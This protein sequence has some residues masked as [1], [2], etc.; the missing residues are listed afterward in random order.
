MSN[1]FNNFKLDKWWRI[2]LWLGILSVT[3]SFIYTPDF[4]EAKNLFGLGLGMILVGLSFVIAERS[5]S[6]IKPPNVYTG[7]AALIT[8]DATEH[9]LV[10]RTICLI[11]I[12]LVGIFGF[13]IIKGLI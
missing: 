3:G 12:C 5:Y 2:V 7:G 6:W 10:T 4:I 9:N 11:G 13:L 1:L 8:Q